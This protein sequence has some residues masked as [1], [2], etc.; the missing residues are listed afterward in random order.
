MT[1]KGELSGPQIQQ[2]K[3]SRV[4][5]KKQLKGVDE[6]GGGGGG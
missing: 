3:R 6:Y 4:V 2:S 5:I 1:Y